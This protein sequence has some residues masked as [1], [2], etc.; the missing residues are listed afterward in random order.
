M[1]SGSHLGQVASLFIEKKHNF[2]FWGVHIFHFQLHKKENMFQ[3]VFLEFS[4][5]KNLHKTSTYT[6]VRCAKV[7]RINFVTQGVP[8]FLFFQDYATFIPQPRQSLHDL[9]TLPRMVYIS[10]LEIRTANLLKKE[11]NKE[12]EIIGNKICFIYCEDDHIFPRWEFP[13][14]L[15]E[16]KCV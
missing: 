2:N 16:L 6:M 12:R 4:S 1:K 5:K 7:P 9:R 10:A 14:L 15:C 8:A 13:W 3:G 11:Q